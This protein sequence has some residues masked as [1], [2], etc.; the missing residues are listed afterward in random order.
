MNAV[1]VM[2]IFAAPMVDQLSV[3]L[4]PGAMVESL[5][6]KEVMVGIEFSAVAVNGDPQPARPT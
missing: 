2:A 5:A 4:D 1:G 6:A 3:L